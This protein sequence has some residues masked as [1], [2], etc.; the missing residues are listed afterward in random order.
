MWY[1]THLFNTTV[2]QDQWWWYIEGMAELEH[3]LESNAQ[4]METTEH[5][6]VT[7]EEDTTVLHIDLNDDIDTLD[8]SIEE[9]IKKTENIEKDPEK[10]ST[11]QVNADVHQFEGESPVIEVK[12]IDRDSPIIDL[13]LQPSF[14]NPRYQDKSRLIEKCEED[15]IEAI[16]EVCMEAQSIQF[17]TFIFRNLKMTNLNVLLKKREQRKR[18]KKRKT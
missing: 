10:D 6:I 13:D 9:E 3:G 16:E 12:S 5:V 14:T 7:S 18:N 2:P 15:K 8:D 11:L 17:I 1:S 4:V